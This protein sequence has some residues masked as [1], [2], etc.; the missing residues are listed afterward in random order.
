MHC[1]IT[2]YLKLSGV[3]LVFYDSW[4]R[5]AQRTQWGWLVSALWCLEPQLGA[6]N[7]CGWLQQLAK[8]ITWMLFMY[9]SGA[10]DE[11]VW[12]LDS[13][14]IVCQNAYIC[15][16]LW[17]GCPQQGSFS[18]VRLLT[19]QLR[20]PREYA[21]EQGGNC[22]AF[23]GLAQGSAH[24]SVKGQIVNRYV[25]RMVSLATS[26]ACCYSMRVAIGST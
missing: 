1:Y 7:V 22:M 16:P 20:T 18:V 12:S 19:R 9:I 4:I 10:W 26:Q 23:C 6:W 5:K 25:G 14:G 11:I 2:N 8:R 17:P 21:S 3:K 15:F 24:F 13:A